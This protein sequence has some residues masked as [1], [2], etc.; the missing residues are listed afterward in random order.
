MS[1]AVERERTWLVRRLP[2]LPEGTPIRQG[3][4]VRDGSVT[5]RVRQKGEHHVVTVKG[6]GTSSRTEI[7]WPIA[8]DQFAALWDLTEGRRVQKTR[9][10]LPV[11]GGIAEL[12]VFAGALDGL[13]LVEVEFGSDQDMAAFDAP[14]WFGPEVTDRPEYTNAA[15]ACGG[16]PADH[17]DLPERA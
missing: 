3:Y 13:V 14:D 9:Y 8:A 1:D 7:E 15:L 4:L 17:P 12:D 6:W 10:E 16:I 11:E 2:E 5:V